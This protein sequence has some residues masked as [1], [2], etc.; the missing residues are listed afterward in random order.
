[1][2]RIVENDSVKAMVEYC[3]GDPFG[4]R[5][6]ANYY[7]YGLGE[8]YAQF[9]LQLDEKENITA[10]IGSLDNGI[11][12]CAR[13]EYD[14]E[15]ID[16]FVHMLAGETGAL[17]PVRKDE[18]ADGLVM[19]LDRSE[20]NASGEDA[21]IN[22]PCEDVYTVI[23]NCPGLGFDVPP[24]SVF[25]PDMY[26]RLKAG[27]DMTA[28]ARSGIMPV[29][30]AAMHLAGGVGLLTMCATV[31]VYEHKGFASTC[32]RTIIARQQP[33]LDIYVM[34]QPQYFSYY[35]QFGFRVV[36]GFCN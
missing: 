17:R 10:A 35:E 4:C 8:G 7:S 29:S 18:T 33:E 1:M 30:C 32:V 22:P 25:Y 14:T 28:V 9:W 34:C 13:G 19:R 11:T 26:R 16:T 27:T 21:E 6:L 2:I 31:P 24:F 3:K 12:I 23:E 5:L 20:F 15:E 36:G